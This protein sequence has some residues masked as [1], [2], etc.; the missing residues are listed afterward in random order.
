MGRCAERMLDQGLNDLG[1][2]F[3]CSDYKDLLWFGHLVVLQVVDVPLWLSTAKGW[4]AIY[5]KCKQ[6]LDD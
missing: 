3:A 1:A 4:M 5:T 2:E 6:N